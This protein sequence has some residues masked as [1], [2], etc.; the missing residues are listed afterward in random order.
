MAQTTHSCARPL[1][2]K[3]KIFKLHIEIF[4]NILAVKVNTGISLL[5]GYSK[6][7]MWF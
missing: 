6:D 4:K 3:Q 2:E 1:P 7:L 5:Y